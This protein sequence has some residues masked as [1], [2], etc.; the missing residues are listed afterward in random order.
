M[1]NSTAAAAAAA[2]GAEV[3]CNLEDETDR[4]LEEEKNEVSFK[5]Q[6]MLKQSWFLQ[7]AVNF[8]TVSPEWHW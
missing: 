4:R 2:V 5:N 1:S 6:I 7:S 3:T 8:Q